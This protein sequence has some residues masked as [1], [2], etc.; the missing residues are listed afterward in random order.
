[1]MSQKAKTVVFI[2]VLLAAVVLAGWSLLMK[3]KT[4]S[5]CDTG[6]SGVAGEEAAPCDPAKKAATCGPSDC[7]P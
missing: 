2:V 4:Q 6:G 7:G 5:G 1:M 3:A